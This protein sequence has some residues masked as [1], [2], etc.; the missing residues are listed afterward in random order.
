MPNPKQTALA[1]LSSLKIS[2]FNAMAE[3]EIHAETALAAGRQDEHTAMMLKLGELGRS[4]RK[5]RDA[6]DKIR[7][8]MPIADTISALD[9]VA[10]QARTTLKRL[11]KTADVLE[12]IATLIKIVGNLSTILT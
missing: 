8:S 2:I 6:E 5:I 11:K 1:K 3:L 10:A 4:A 9:D 12:E 7:A